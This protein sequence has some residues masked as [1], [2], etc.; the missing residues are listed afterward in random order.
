MPS[1]SSTRP[2]VG[3]GTVPPFLDY[4]PTYKYVDS[5]RAWERV[6]GGRHAGTAPGQPLDQV[7]GFILLGQ[8]HD[9]IAGARREL[10]TCLGT[11]LCREQCCCLHST[12]L[13]SRLE[14]EYLISRTGY[15]SDLVR[16]AEDWLLAPHEEAPSYPLDVPTAI[17]GT[18]TPLRALPQVAREMRALAARRSPFVLAERNTARERLVSGP[19]AKTSYAGGTAQVHAENVDLLAQTQPLTCAVSGVF[20]LPPAHCTR[21]LGLG[22]SGNVRIVADP[23]TLQHYWAALQAIYRRVPDKAAWGFLPTLIVAA[24]RPMQFARYV[25]AGKV[26]LAKLVMADAATIPPRLWDT[27]VAGMTERRITSSASGAS[28]GTRGASWSPVGP[29]LATGAPEA[30]RRRWS[31]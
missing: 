28:G 27:A 15:Y 20:T 23:T 30:A 18:P 21:R 6:S 12:P 31:V 29:A 1:P 3:G 14:A 26:A 24:A 13:V 4:I 9:Y 5:H 10:E 8:M 2:T 11:P 16:L 19:W 25:R 7:Q 17:G 22:E